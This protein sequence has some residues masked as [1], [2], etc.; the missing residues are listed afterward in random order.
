M[1]CMTVQ[2]WFAPHAGAQETVTA[3]R[4]EERIFYHTVERG[5]TVYSISLMY[6]VGEEDIYRL[7]PSSRERVRAGEELRIPQKEQADGRKEN[8]DETYVYHTIRTGE[9]LYGV[10]RQ[11]GLSAEDISEANRGLTPETFAA[12][13]TI[14]IPAMRMQSLPVTQTKVVVK[15]LKYKIKRQETMY[16]ICRKFDVTSEELLAYNPR[17]KSGLKA[18]MELII[19]V[20]TEEIVTEI[21][22]QRELNIE[23]L[24]N[25]RR[26]IERTNIARIA[27][28]LP[29]IDPATQAPLDARVIEFYEGFL[30]SVDSMRNDGMSVELYVY[31]IGNDAATTATALENIESPLP[32]LL[33]GGMTDIQIELIAD[34]ARDRNIKYVVPFSSRCERLTLD[35]PCIFQVN[36][37]PQNLYSYLTPRIHTLFPRHRIVLLNT[38]DGNPKTQ[39]VHMLGADL[40]DNAIPFAEVTFSE[41]TFQA[42]MLAAMSN[43]VPNLVIPFSGSLDALLKIKSTLRSIAETKPEYSVTLFGHPEWQNYTK[44]CLDDFYALNT[45]FYTPAYMN[46][47]TPEAKWFAGKY[48]DMYNKP[49]SPSSPRYAVLGY[50]LGMYFLTAIRTYGNTFDNYVH[51]H[52]YRSIQSG[53]RFG[54]VNNWGGFFNTNLYIVHY[55]KKNYSILREE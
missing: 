5:Q 37:M 22:A 12:G 32:D 24:I 31:N 54:R 14:R 39:L 41:K 35:N 9:T 34:F 20:R 48:K 21:P 51:Q 10:S 16:S 25:Y 26:Q 1:L 33:V 44:D 23:E 17:L 53:F 47:M 2:T 7:N 46:T 43:T 52:V 6:G 38:N 42:D 30:M 29:F 49:L 11:Y 36:A 50:D 8:D 28:L 18:G 27:L 3:V 13:K 40:N 15:E 45:Y 55:N 19:P 4:Q